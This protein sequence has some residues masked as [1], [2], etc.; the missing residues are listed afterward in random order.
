MGVI[1]KQLRLI[2]MGLL[3]IIKMQKG[4]T[5]IELLITIALAAILMP[6][7]LGGFAIARSGRAQQEQRIAAVSLAKESEEAV[8]V[9]AANSW[10]NMK[11]G[12]Y[13]AT[14]SGTTWV[15][16]SGSAQI[17]GFT[18]SI[19]ISSVNRD[20]SGNI[21]IVGG[22]LDPSTK[23]ISISVSWLT[24]IPASI[25]PEFFL[26]RHKNLNK[27]ETTTTDFSGGI[28]SGTS[29]SSTNP[30]VVAGDGQIQLGAGGGAGGGDWCQPSDSVLRTF[31]LPGQGVVQSIS[32][33]SS[34]SINYA[35]TTTGGNASGN[36]V[37]KL[38]IS[39]ANPP[40]ILN[41]AFNN[42]AKAYGIFVDQQGQYVYFNENNPPSHTVAITSG[43]DLSVIGYFD[44]AN[45]TGNSIYVNGN[46]GYTT[47]GTNLYIFDVSSKIGSRP[48]LKT[49][50]LNGNGKRVFVVG[51]KAYVAT[52]NTTNQLQVFNVSDLNNVT[53]TNISMGNALSGVDVFVDGTQTYAYFVT[54]Y[55][56][57]KNN[58]FIVDLNSPGNIYAYSTN[59]MS[60]KG[61]IAVP[62]N[63]AIIVGSG[64]TLYQVFDTTTPA[65]ASYCGGMTPA[66]VTSINAVSYVIQ[67]DGK[68]YSYILTNN[69]SAEF[70]V[71]IG[72][73][74]SGEFATTG[75]FVSSPFK[76]TH[77]SFFNSFTATINQ[78]AQTSIQLQVASAQAVGGS[79]FGAS[80]TFVGP[81]GTPG[82]YYTPSGNTISGQIPLS[83]S[84]S[85]KNPADCFEYK[86]YF[87]SND[88]TLTPILYDFTLNY[89]P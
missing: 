11:D 63:R 88:D 78:P 20:L 40:V 70:Q 18:R 23:K 80:Y 7:L 21:T 17:N 13:H 27:N 4:Q 65:S 45:M 43:S 67:S 19:E 28:L 25:T 33:T 42:D 10:S 24:P 44:I 81:D 55:S 34:A 38:T 8:R 68:V 29:I 57:G 6:A 66:G 59:G 16:A 76:P 37:D 49:I 79:C 50:T 30:P 82:T 51:T 53:T 36:A 39:Y 87:S 73:P 12:T 85:F 54:S 9:V 15:L 52:D 46:Y 41:P 32:S 83:G 1:L 71:V 14:P 86:A 22:S 62:R 74:G 2:N 47:S 5:L 26:T 69:A 3:Q 77:E 64:G 58:F 48:L 56:S 84:G 72:G 61:V 31:D 35:F 75:T 89:S 60:P